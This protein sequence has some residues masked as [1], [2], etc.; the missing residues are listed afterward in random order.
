MKIYENSIEHVDEFPLVKKKR[1]TMFY[2]VFR[3]KVRRNSR[4]TF[5]VYSFKGSPPKST[6]VNLCLSLPVDGGERTGKVRRVEKGTDGEEDTVASI[7]IKVYPS[8]YRTEDIQ[9]KITVVE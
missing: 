2:V 1:N 8:T 7:G 4:L 9:G 5:N 3:Y 6:P